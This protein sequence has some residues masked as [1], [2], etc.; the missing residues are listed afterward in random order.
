MPANVVDVEVVL[1]RQDP[2]E[3][4][5]LDRQ[6]EAHRGRGQAEQGEKGAGLVLLEGAHAE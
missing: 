1:S 3:G 2:A 6:R 5:N 4:G